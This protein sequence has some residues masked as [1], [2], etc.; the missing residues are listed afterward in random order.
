MEKSNIILFGLCTIAIFLV[1]TTIV[2]ASGQIIPGIIMGY[3][4]SVNPEGYVFLNGSDGNLNATNRLLIGAGDT[5]ALGETGGASTH[6]H[7]HASDGGQLNMFSS[8]YPL[9]IIQTL[10]AGSKVPGGSATKS[11]GTTDAVS[12]YPATYGS[13]FME[14]RI[15][16]NTIKA[17]SEFWWNAS[18][19]DIPEGTEVMSEIYNRFMVGAGGLW[20]SGETAG[21]NTHTDY[22][23]VSGTFSLYNGPVLGGAGGTLGTSGTWSGVLQA[24]GQNSIPLSWGLI[25]LRA[26]QDIPLYSHM[27]FGF[28]GTL[29]SLNNT[30]FS[31]F[32]DT[33]DKFII[34]A[35]DTFDVGEETGSNSHTGTADWGGSG[36]LPSGSTIT[37]GAH[38]QQWLNLI[39]I[40]GDLTLG[41]ADNTPPYLAVYFVEYYVEENCWTYENEYLSI[42]PECDY[43]DLGVIIGEIS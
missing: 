2:S 27:V 18:I 32:E 16:S 5:Y 38:P 8:G 29:A 39:T 33:Y 34:S 14:A 30:G 41:S 20:D 7:P 22:D 40:G 12:N 19:E 36:T 26:T 3:N 11:S 35:G 25:P 1:L 23:T 6:T 24:I 31:V 4:E 28:N 13:N 43:Q 9:T 37:T 10:P 15:E 17:G 21:S 42:P